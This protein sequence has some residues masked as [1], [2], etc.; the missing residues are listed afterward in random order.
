MA[1][2]V[3]HQSLSHILTGGKTKQKGKQ[4][5]CDLVSDACGCEA[6]DEGDT[7]EAHPPKEDGAGWLHDKV[8]QKNPQLREQC[9]AVWVSSWSVAKREESIV[10]EG[11][12]Q[13]SLATEEHEN[14][15]WHQEDLIAGNEF[16]D[17]LLIG[18][19]FV[20]EVSDEHQA[21]GPHWIKNFFG[22]GGGMK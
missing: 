21:A 3:P 5:F 11:Q 6:A 9:A 2:T 10:N 15:G 22:V 12:Q 8:L 16:E 18:C 7:A 13:T 14:C 1:S 20:Q 17:V 4:S 19:K